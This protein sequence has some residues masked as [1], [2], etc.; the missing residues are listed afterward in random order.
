M[1]VFRPA[2]PEALKS[3]FPGFSV[4]ALSAF[5]C[6]VFVRPPEGAPTP[7]LSATAD[8]HAPPSKT[9]S[10][11]HGEAKRTKENFIF[12]IL[13]WRIGNSLREQRRPAVVTRPYEECRCWIV[14]AKQAQRLP[15]LFPANRFS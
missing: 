9:H 15:V 10:A 6:R 3:R 4:S 11:T 12:Y 5:Y 8:G 13:E 2:T 14:A 1:A 7:L